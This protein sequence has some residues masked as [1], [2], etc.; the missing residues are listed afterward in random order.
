MSRN[1]EVKIGLIRFLKVIINKR[2]IYQIPIRDLVVEI[3]R[4]IIYMNNQ[5]LIGQIILIMKMIMK[6][7]FRYLFQIKN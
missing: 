2:I 6:D 3:Y 7:R 1:L 5:W 4:Y